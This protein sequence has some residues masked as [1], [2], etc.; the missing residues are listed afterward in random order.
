MPEN[1]YCI[2]FRYPNTCVHPLAPNTWFGKPT[3]IEVVPHTS[4]VRVPRFCALK[5]PPPK[6]STPLNVPS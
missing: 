4:D 3:C 2:A 6:T 1:V 5:H